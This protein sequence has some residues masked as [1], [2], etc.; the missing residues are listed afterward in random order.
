[1][2]M[3]RSVQRYAAEGGS[4]KKACRD[5]NIHPKQF[6]EWATNFKTLK[7][8][9]PTAKS[10]F[11]GPKSILESVEHNLLSFIFELREQGMAIS[12]SMIVLKACTL[13]QE[14]REKS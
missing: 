3:V 13:L 4:V 2:A 14:F 9:N 10:A 6:R 7:E 5:L 1:M 12:I 8:R 11:Q